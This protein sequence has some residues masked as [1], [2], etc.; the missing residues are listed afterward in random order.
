MTPP[1]KARKVRR[2]L[3]WSHIIHTARGSGKTTAMIEAVK[4]IKGILVVRDSNE[5]QRIRKQHGILAISIYEHER[6]Y[7]WNIPILFDPDAVA[8]LCMAH[9]KD[10]LNS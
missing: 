2:V 9:E 3:D 5:A 7:G 10:V 8:M 1:K 6:T 4:K